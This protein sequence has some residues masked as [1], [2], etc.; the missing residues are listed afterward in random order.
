MESAASLFFL[1]PPHPLSFVPLFPQVFILFTE[2]PIIALNGISDGEKG[3]FL[4]VGIT[5]FVKG[6]GEGFLGL[7]SS[8]HD[9]FL[10]P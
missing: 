8:V 1:L 10:R 4:A 3:W 9:F 6:G 2:S 7:C 5:D